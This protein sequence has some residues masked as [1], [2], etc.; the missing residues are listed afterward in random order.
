MKNKNSKDL[1]KTQTLSLPTENVVFRN[2]K[3]HKLQQNHLMVTRL[4]SSLGGATYWF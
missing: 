2:L 3:T 1:T 4:A